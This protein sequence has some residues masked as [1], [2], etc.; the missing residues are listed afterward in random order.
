[1]N[2]PPKRINELV[3]KEVRA[4]SA[5]CVPNAEGLVK[6]DA[7]ENPHSLPEKLRQAWLVR[8]AAVEINRYPDPQCRTLKRKLRDI[9]DINDDHGVVLGNGS[10]ELIQMLA[11][12]VGGDGKI[13]LAPTPTFSM[14]QLIATTTGCQ[15]VGVP[16]RADFNLDGDA[17]LAAIRKH[18]P[19][20]VFLAL[21]NNPTGNCFAE[22]IIAEVLKQAPGIVVLDEA[23]F[24]FCQRSFLPRL[25]QFPDLMV[26]R[27]L[28][29]SGMAGL[30][31]GLLIAHPHWT[32]QLEKIRLP[33]NINSLTQSSVQFYLEHHAVMQQQAMQIIAQREVVFERLRNK[34]GVHPY[35]SEANFILFSL[36]QD[37][38]QIYNRIREQGVLIKNLHHTV[39]LANH[40]RVTIGSESENE[41]FLEALNNSLSV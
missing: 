27:T 6:L 16:L 35:P 4:V 14:Y 5:Y 24:A 3:R 20:C 15:F 10:D 30:R 29:K 13:L 38:K 37:A 25:Q 28:S 36:E 32:E 2:N 21:P 40:L 7:M 23:Y 26:L 18:Q 11:L 33:Y 19:A 12:L 31:L 22:E 39:A 9:Y 1:M 17:L 34:P 41:Q 8:L